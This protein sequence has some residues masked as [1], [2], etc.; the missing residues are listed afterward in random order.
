MTVLARVADAILKNVNEINGRKALVQEAIDS[1]SLFANANAKLNTRQKEL[2]KPDLHSYYKYLCSASMSVTAEL[3]GDDLSK[4]VQDI[5]E[6]K[7]VDRKVTST[8]AHHRGHSHTHFGYKI[9]IILWKRKTFPSEGPTEAFFRLATDRKSR[10]Y[11]SEFRL[12]QAEGSK[13]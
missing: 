11:H 13:K 3:F 9:S 12:P 8:M 1:L 6:V 4:Q 10:S 5:S 7:W 2:I